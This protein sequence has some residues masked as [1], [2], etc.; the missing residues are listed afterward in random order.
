MK[1]LTF[2]EFVRRSKKVHGNKYIYHEETFKNCSTK[3][4]ITYP[5][6]GDFWQ[7]P[8]D[9]MNGHGYKRTYDIESFV[10]EFTRKFPDRNYTFEKAVFK[11]THTKL[12]ATCH[13]KDDNGVEHGD[14]EIRPGDLLSGYGCFRCSNNNIKY[15]NEEFIDK[16]N[17]VHNFKFDYSCTEYDGMNRTV[18]VIC[19]RKDKNGKEHGM[20]W[21]IAA[22]HLN[23][24]GCPRCNTLSKSKFEENI[25][26][27]IEQQICKPERQKTFEW[28]RYKKKLFLDYYIDKYKIAVEVQGEQHFVPIERF[29]GVEQFEIQCNRDRI[30]K[31]LCEEHGIKI[32][33]ITKKKNNIDDIIRYIN[34]TT[35]KRQQDQS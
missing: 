3:T 12:V 8:S 14:F 31:E 28:L 27:L 17:N 6:V 20:W 32:F 2:E 21:P 23:G 35:N 24:N 9:H 15:T 30:K 16:A 19:H 5:N 7:R 13:C 11:N 10:N 1:K 34:E 22:N 26:L 29:G 33:Y 25:G 4:L 18:C